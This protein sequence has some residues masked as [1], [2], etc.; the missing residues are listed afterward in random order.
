MRFL[1]NG[2]AGYHKDSNGNPQPD[3]INEV[4]GLRISSEEDGGELGYM[5]TDGNWA[6]SVYEGPY[7]FNRIQIRRSN[8]DD[9]LGYDETGE[10]CLDD[11][12]NSAICNENY[13]NPNPLQSG[14]SFKIE[15]FRIYYIDQEATEGTGVN[16]INSGYGNRCKVEIISRTDLLRA[17]G[18]Q[19]D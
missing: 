19:V 3:S 10:E 4:R 7:D 14:D 18:H 8:V 13:G 15:N 2:G 12:S 16:T 9:Y 11:G 17:R 1:V 6:V 5:D